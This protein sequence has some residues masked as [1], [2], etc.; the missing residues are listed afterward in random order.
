MRKFLLGAIVAVAMACVFGGNCFADAAGGGVPTLKALFPDNRFEVKYVGEWSDDYFYAS[1][2]F[3]K[4]DVGLLQI[5]SYDLDNMTIY[6]NDRACDGYEPVTCGNST[7]GLT[8][9]P[10]QVS[11]DNISEIRRNVSGIPSVV[12]MDDVY[13]AIDRHLMQG[14]DDPFSVYED[15]DFSPSLTEYLLSN[16]LSLD[17]TGGAGDAWG[18]IYSSSNESFSVR[19]GDVYVANGKEIRFNSSNIIYIPENTP[20]DHESVID[21]ISKQIQSKSW[22]QF[23]WSIKPKNK[24]TYYCG[25]FMESDD[26]ET[27]HAEIDLYELELDDFYPET[28]IAVV[29]ND[30]KLEPKKISVYNSDVWLTTD[31]RN[32]FRRHVYVEKLEKTSEEIN[33]DTVVPILYGT[34]FRIS[35][36]YSMLQPYYDYSLYMGGEVEISGGLPLSD[37][38]KQ[39]S[40]NEYG[41]IVIEGNVAVYSVRE[42]GWVDK[43]ET[44]N[45]SISHDTRFSADHLG[46]FIVAQDNDRYYTPI[47]GLQRAYPDGEYVLKYAGNWSDDYYYAAVNQILDEVPD[48]RLRSYD[49]ANERVTFYGVYCQPIY[50]SDGTYPESFEVYRSEPRQTSHEGLVQYGVYCMPV[51]SDITIPIRRERVDLSNL[52]EIQESA[53]R[54]RRTFETEGPE[55]VQLMDGLDYESN[56]KAGAPFI[57]LREL[58]EYLQANYLRIQPISRTIEGANNESAYYMGESNNVI[59]YRDIFVASSVNIGLKGAA[60][61]FIPE[62]TPSDEESITAAIVRQLALDDIDFDYWDDRTAF[63]RVEDGVLYCGGFEV[64]DCNTY[65]DAYRVTNGAKTKTRIVAVVRDSKKALNSTIKTEYKDKDSGVI[66]R[67]GGRFIYNT[68]LN[69]TSTDNTDEQMNSNNWFAYYPRFV[70]EDKDVM[71]GGSGDINECLAL[72]G[73]SCNYEVSLPIVSNVDKSRLVI[74]RTSRSDSSIIDEAIDDFEIEDNMVRF[75]SDS[76]DDYFLKNKQSN[77]GWRGDVYIRDGR[78][79]TGLQEIDGE[80]YYFDPATKRARRGQLKIGGYWYYF[81]SNTKAMA[82]SKFITLSKAET[83]DGPKTV[84]Y[85]K[86][87]HMLYGFRTISGNR[88]Y[89]KPNNGALQKGHMKVDGYW[90]MFDSSSGAMKRSEFYT[91]KKGESGDAPKTVYFDENGH[92]LYGFQNVGGQ[93]YYLHKKSGALQKG[94]QKIDGHWYYMDSNSGVVAK[95]KFITLSR[96]ETKDGPKTVYYDKS[97]HMLYGL[98][99]IG[100][101]IYYLKKGSG[102]LQKGHMKVDGYWYFFDKNTGVAKKSTFYTMQPGESGD[103]PKTVY[104]DGKG[105]VVYGMQYI[106]GRYYYFQ[107]GSGRLLD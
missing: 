69:V 78:P 34:A 25:G 53:N 23:G 84:Y 90:Y 71:Y 33:N 1:A 98:R 100:G 82:K 15:S 12:E 107:K 9:V 21:A 63:E 8:I 104:F 89:L 31:F 57:R 19:Y 79:V 10:E 58:K 92:L 18:D 14:A 94:Q 81:D 59:K 2:R 87:G 6:F 43:Y 65:V 105:H 46:E 17:L 36:S 86:N 47:L 5:A 64:G 85:D 54:L 22:L 50:D 77:N 76:I 51:Y 101:N 97:G 70:S 44:V 42:D 32:L 73:V 88:Y 103:A 72:T 13:N 40:V 3:L 27:C 75:E 11:L 29:R 102:A 93:T 68:W 60:V 41:D 66:I 37:E 28:T 38:L 96:A 45:D 30:S 55:A 52:N 16:N 99:N 61:V 80:T 95:S 106:N 83:N 56:V 48:L 35:T 39:Y 91:M 24:T 20:N 67:Y 4:K 26:E 49:L 7:Y 74:T 62:D